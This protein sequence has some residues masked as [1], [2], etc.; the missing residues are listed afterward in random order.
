MN[1]SVKDS[2]E[3][4]YKLMRSLI[5]LI[6]VCRSRDTW[7]YW[8]LNIEKYFSKVE[9]WTMSWCL[10]LPSPS[11][12]MPRDL[13]LTIQSCILSKDCQV[14]EW[15]EWSACS[16]TC[17]DP[18]S[19]RGNRTRRRQ[20]LQFPVGEGVECP[21]LEEM[22]SC[23]PQGESLPPCTTW[24]L[25]T[26]RGGRTRQ[27]GLKGDASNCPKVLMWLSWLSLRCE[28]ALCRHE[29]ICFD[30]ALLK[31]AMRRFRR[32]IGISVTYGLETEKSV[33]AQA[34]Q[35]SCWPPFTHITRLMFSPGWHTVGSVCL[36]C[37]C[38]WDDIWR[39]ISVSAWAGARHKVKAVEG[40]YTAILHSETDQTK[41]Q[42]VRWLSSAHTMIPHPCLSEELFSNPSWKM[43][44]FSAKPVAVSLTH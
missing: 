8:P 1:V 27:L 10:S 6:Q 37:A 33:L 17:M 15:T 3:R 41:I 42:A 20:V 28:C 24:V 4:D 7:G 9:I 11:R 5:Y 21:P 13:P 14:T 30:F 32:S 38:L 43:T 26:E 23:E 29:I 35:T 12:C 31:P 44:G 39:K 25:I 34:A 18:E 19:L 22:E 16:K 36:C 40:N 2:V